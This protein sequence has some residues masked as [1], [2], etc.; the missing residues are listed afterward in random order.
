M[1]KFALEKLLHANNE[2]VCETHAEAIRIETLKF[3]LI[4]V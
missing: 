1:L 4:L 3:P 2:G